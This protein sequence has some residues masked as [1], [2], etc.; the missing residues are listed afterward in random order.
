MSVDL[1]AELENIL[2]T[3]WPS[4]TTHMIDG[5]AVRFANGYSARSNSASAITPGATMTETLLNTIMPMYRDAG[6]PTQV[7]V[8]PVAHHDTTH[9]LQT[10][11]FQRINQ[12]ITMTAPLTQPLTPSPLVTMLAT[13]ERIWLDGISARQSGSKRNPNHLHTIVS[14]LQ[15]PAVFAMLEADGQPVGFGLC[16]IDKGWAEFGNIMI[17]ASHRGKGLG[18][19]LFSSL[20]HWAQNNGARNA[21]LQVDA[22]NSIAISL[23][24]SLGFAHAY[25]YKTW[26][27]PRSAQ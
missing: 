18:R 25:D 23:Y 2:L 8:T 20:L 22:D 24:R 11:G 3:V 27:L 10:R 4:V 9:M 7:R 1:V 12:A 16:A 14:R 13:P 19:A 21:F 15:V 6:L 5:W 17:D 26:S